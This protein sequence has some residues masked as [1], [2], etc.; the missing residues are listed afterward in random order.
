MCR[1]GRFIGAYMD[2]MIR[3]LYMQ[4]QM[5]KEY[6]DPIEQRVR[7][8]LRNL[9]KC[10]KEPDKEEMLQSAVKKEVTGAETG[11]KCEA[12]IKKRFRTSENGQTNERGS[13]ETEKSARANEAISDET[14]KI[15]RSTSE[16]FLRDRPIVRCGRSWRR[17]RICAR[18]PLWVSSLYG[19]HAGG[20]HLVTAGSEPLQC[21]EK[22]DKSQLLRF[23]KSGSFVKQ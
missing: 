16:R 8:E 3:K 7:E 1:P 21:F 15:C 12:E 4:M 22:F 20:N 14:E 17:S 10:T 11:E 5:E 2:E 13:S 19:M 18:L 6:D 9:L 23:R